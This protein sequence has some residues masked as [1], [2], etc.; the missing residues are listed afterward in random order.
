MERKALNSPTKK[1]LSPE[2][3]PQAQRQNRPEF[4]GHLL[5]FYYITY[6]YIVP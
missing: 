5:L 1:E 3:E 6:L 2:P 4:A